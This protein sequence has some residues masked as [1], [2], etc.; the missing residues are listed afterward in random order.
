MKQT[1][2]VHSLLVMLL[3]TLLMSCSRKEIS[4]ITTEASMDFI[5]QTYS[6]PSYG[7]PYTGASGSEASGLDIGLNLAAMFLIELNDMLEVFG[8]PQAAKTPAGPPL[9]SLLASNYPGLQLSRFQSVNAHRPPA[10][11][12]TIRQHLAFMSGLEL[13]GKGARQTTGG[14][15]DKTS[16]LYLE[17]PIYAI[18]YQ[19]LANKGRVFGGIGPYIAYGLSG[20]FNSTTSG[21]S[22]SSPAFGT[23]GGFQRFDA[24]IAL[25]AGYQ[26]TNSLR[27]RLAYDLGLA[28][29]ESGP[30]GTNG[31]KTFNR[32]L[33]LN[34]GYP[35]EKLAG[36]VKKK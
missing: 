31:D 25:T 32:T 4:F 3:A 13:T 36:L 21:R 11:W 30:S 15:T 1:V 33:S 27:F 10:D 17:I 6:G 7:N 34:V 23:N 12:A 5:G 9:G 24:G 8:N 22:F 2:C 28:N 18:Y 35:L 16:L 26:L 29:I 20:T 14:S 19:N